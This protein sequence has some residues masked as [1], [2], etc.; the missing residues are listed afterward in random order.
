ML[1][2]I[3]NDI[4]NSRFVIILIIIYL[5]FMQLIFSTWCPIKAIFHINCPGC[6]LTHATIYIFTGQLEKAI[7]ANYTVFLWWILIVLFFINRYIYKFSM[8]IFWFFTVL[9]SI[10]TIL[11]YIINF[12]MLN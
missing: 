12:M 1:N 6:G 10:I 8:K 11:R 3:K 9:V 2:K 5:I 7:D 4:Y